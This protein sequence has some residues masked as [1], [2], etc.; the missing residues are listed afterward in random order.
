MTTA[1]RETPRSGGLDVGRWGLLTLIATEGALFAYLLASYFYVGVLHG[2][3]PTTGAPALTIAAPNTIILLASS[4]TV[5]WAE[6]GGRAGNGRRLRLGLGLTLLLGGAFLALQGVEY[7]HARVT[8]RTDVYGSL[9]FAITGMHGAHVVVGLLILLHTAA[10][11]F[12]GHFRGGRQVAV[13]NAALYW[14]FVDAV[15]ILVFTSL[16]IGPRL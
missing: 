9:F 10:R 6:R 4:G 8:P 7:A 16:Y 3:W 2:T 14:H 12:A 13:R 1:A 11:A 15:W 5:W